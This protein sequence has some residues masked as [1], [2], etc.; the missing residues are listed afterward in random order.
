MT[1]QANRGPPESRRG[2]PDAP[3]PAWVESVPPEEM[4]TE[5]T[6]A[7][8]VPLRAARWHPSPKTTVNSAYCL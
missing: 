4:C 7:I 2:P 1:L 5:D 3:A 8:C 6:S